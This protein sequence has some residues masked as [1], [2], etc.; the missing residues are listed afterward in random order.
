MRDLGILVVSG[1]R[2]GQ[3][4]ASEY[5]QFF[6]LV[7]LA[8]TDGNTFTHLRLPIFL[9]WNLTLLS[10]PFPSEMTLT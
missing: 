7:P 3:G 8:I 2:V 10:M 4:H 5:L 1:G 6:F 9:P